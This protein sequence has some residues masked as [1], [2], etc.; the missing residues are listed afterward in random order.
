MALRAAIVS[1]IPFLLTTGAALLL[2]LI[3]LSGVT[4]TNPLNR[5]FYMEADTSAISGAPAT[6]RWTLWNRCGVDSNG[7]NTDCT[8]NKPAYAFQPVVNFGTSSGVPSSLI[9]HH[10]MY[11]YLSRFSFAFYFLAAGFAC[12]AWL[13]AWVAFSMVG[14]LVTSIL[15]FFA[16]ITAIIA[17]ALSTALYVYV[18]DDFNN[19]GYSAHLGVKL[20]AFA[21]SAVACLLLSAPGFLVACCLARRSK[22]YREPTSMMDTDATNEKRSFFHRRRRDRLP[23]VDHESQQHV[24]EPIVQEPERT[25]YAL[26]EHVAHT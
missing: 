17:A 8:A 14:A 22:R 15:S 18:R 24:M 4:E 11:F 10:K 13:A 6:T 21:W 9:D 16:L 5:I 12:L 20:F 1:A 2:L 19:A 25:S 3:L 26:E 23:S 7:H